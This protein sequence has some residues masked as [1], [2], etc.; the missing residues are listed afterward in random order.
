MNFFYVIYDFLSKKL[1]IE[2]KKDKSA[3]V[4]IFKFVSY[5]IYVSSAI[6]MVLL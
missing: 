4:Y 6:N 3:C 2:N 1:I 5:N